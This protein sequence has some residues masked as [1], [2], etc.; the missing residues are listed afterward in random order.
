MSVVCTRVCGVCVHV[1]VCI[2]VCVHVC[3]CLCS[4]VRGDIADDRWESGHGTF[5]VMYTG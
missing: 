1:R 3:V 4:C 5:Y 2:C